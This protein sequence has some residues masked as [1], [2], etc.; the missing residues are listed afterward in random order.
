MYCKKC[1][2]EIADDSVFC[3]YCGAKQDIDELG[4][5]ET[6]NNNVVD[7]FEDSN[8][9]YE[10]DHSYE[11]DYSNYDETDYEDDKGQ[12]KKSAIAN[13]I[14]T[15]LKLI[16]LG[17]VLW[18]VY[19]IGFEVYHIKDIKPVS[20]LYWGGSC[21]DGPLQDMYYLTDD[22]AEQAFRRLVDDEKMRGLDKPKYRTLPSGEKI[23]VSFHP[24]WSTMTEQQ[25]EEWKEEEIN[26]DRARFTED[27]NGHRE[28]HHIEN[29]KKHLLWSIIIIMSTLL[30]GRY[31][32]KSVVWVNKNRTH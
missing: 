24:H 10:D 2:K 11:D 3:K 25:K 23:Q 19:M 29:R 9:N 7:S 15:I 8:Q 1:G 30:F 6:E 18:V 28:S 26:I 20:E 12:K 5:I 17:L 21:Y 13:E 4:I 14:V 31:I 22:D 16:C 32:Y 27:V